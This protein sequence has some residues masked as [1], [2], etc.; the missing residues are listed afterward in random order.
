MADTLTIVLIVFVVLILAYYY[1]R[2]YSNQKE[3]EKKKTWPTV[4]NPCPDYWVADDVG[5]CHNKM[6]I[7]SDG[8]KCDAAVDGVL[9]QYSFTAGQY[10]NAETGEY[11]K[12][13]I[14]KRCGQTWEGIDDKC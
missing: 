2:E 1:W 12:C 7:P 10:T 3:E 11:Q 8:S 4:V 9:G 13:R 6:N 5:T 14:M